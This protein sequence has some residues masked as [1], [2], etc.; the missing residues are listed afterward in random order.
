MK[1]RKIKFIINNCLPIEWVHFDTKKNCFLLPISIRP[2]LIPDETKFQENNLY[3]GSGPFNSTC[4]T[5]FD[6]F[7]ESISSWFC[8]LI[9]YFSNFQP[10]SLASNFG[11][12]SK[13]ISFQPA[14]ANYKGNGEEIYCTCISDKSKEECLSSFP[15]TLTW[16]MG[17]FF[18]NPVIII[19]IFYVLRIYNLHWADD[20]GTFVSCWKKG[21]LKMERRILHP[22]K[23]PL[24]HP[25]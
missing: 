17:F 25:W 3:Y 7:A 16:W 11:W 6:Y 9:S 1:S 20:S 22:P 13:G 14:E 18:S 2:A 4:S 15:T 10:P 19:S 24:Y 8:Q 21:E 12:I 5:F 23:P